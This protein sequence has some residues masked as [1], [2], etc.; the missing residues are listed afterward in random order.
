MQTKTRIIATTAVLGA[1]AFAAPAA[2]APALRRQAW[3]MAQP[4]SVEHAT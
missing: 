3:A 4:Q 1:L 2:R